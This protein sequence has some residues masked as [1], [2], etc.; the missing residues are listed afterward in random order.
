ME[1]MILGPDPKESGPKPRFSGWN[2]AMSAFD[3]KDYKNIQRLLE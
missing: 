1:Y 3:Y 2:L